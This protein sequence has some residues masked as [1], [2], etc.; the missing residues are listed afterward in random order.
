MGFCFKFVPNIIS[1]ITHRLKICFIFCHKERDFTFLTSSVTWVVDSFRRSF[2]R[3]PTQLN[4]LIRRI[5]FNFWIALHTYLTSCQSCKNL[6]SFTFRF[7]CNHVRKGTP[8]KP[9]RLADWSHY[10]FI[11][12][13]VSKFRPQH[14]YT[15]SST[16]NDL[17]TIFKEV[18]KWF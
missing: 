8:L 13:S 14:I 15:F 3:D 1:K 17:I 7:N 11:M 9:I 4:R 5:R 10:S 12:L 6:D 2:E 18:P 16:H